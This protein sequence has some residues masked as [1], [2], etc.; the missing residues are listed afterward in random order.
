MGNGVSE[1]E[2][3]GDGDGKGPVGRPFGIAGACWSGAVKKGVY[4]APLGSIWAITELLVVPHQ[5]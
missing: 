1:G 5:L 4:V 3:V 2:G